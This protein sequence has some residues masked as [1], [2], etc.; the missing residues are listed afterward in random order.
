MFSRIAARY[1]L[2]NRLM[3]FGQDSRWRRA[4][5]QKAQLPQ[6]GRLL[7]V[8][9]GTGDIAREGLRA[10]LSLMAVGAD[11]SLEM[12]R[13]G[14]GD[15]DRQGIQWMG[16]DT[17]SLPFPD[18]SFDSVTSGFLMRNVIDVPGAFK[19]Q[20]RVIRPGG[21]VVVLESSP[22]KK[23]L[24]RPLVR[25]HLN[26][27]IPLLGRLVTGDGEAYR[28]LPDSTQ[29]FREPA[30]LAKIMVDCGLEDVTYELF[31]FGTIA[32]HSGRKPA[33]VPNP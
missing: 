9:T 4:V 2:M 33:S 17:L 19:E 20:V 26:T 29:T 18:D 7:D 32:I 25:F 24:L 15:P 16:A 14:R 12:I 13:I 28:Y 21:W 10:D 31:M 5:I 11:F 1:D 23:N 22:P 30:S 6:N 8:G 27:V 3:T